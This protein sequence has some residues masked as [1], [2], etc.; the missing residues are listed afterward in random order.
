MLGAVLL[1]IAVVAVPPFLS[2][3][4]RNSSTAGARK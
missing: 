4:L 1:L 3:R 2:P